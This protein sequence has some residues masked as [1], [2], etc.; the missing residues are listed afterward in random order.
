VFTR[1]KRLVDILIARLRAEGINCVRIT[2]DETSAE[3]DTAMQEFQNPESKVRVVC[4]TA[5]G[6]ES[7][8]LQAAKALVCVDTPWSAGDFLQLIGRM[9]RIGS[10][11]DR[12]H[13]I[14][15]LARNRGGGKSA[16]IDH[17]VMQTLRKKMNLIEAV[18]G[19]RL[20]GVGDEVMISAENEIS[21]IFHDLRA[22][23]REQRGLPPAPATTEEEL[24]ISDVLEL[25]GSKAKEPK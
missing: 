15:L 11:H 2:G 19:K 12:C 4:I 18:L 21:D 22:D 25:I 7:I 10:V 1:F 17:H 14:H 5:A 20:K 16:T 8:N 9:I 24:D 13:V 23:A 3:R 6:S